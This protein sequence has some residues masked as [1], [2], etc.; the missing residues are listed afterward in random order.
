[1]ASVQENGV[2]YEVFHNG[3]SW[4]GLTLKEALKMRDKLNRGGHMSWIKHRR[5]LALDSRLL[6]REYVSKAW[7]PPQPRRFD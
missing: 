4:S 1:M 7:G 6:Q 5:Q 2:N 3:Q